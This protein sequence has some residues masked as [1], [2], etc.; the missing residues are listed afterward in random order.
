MTEDDGHAVAT[1]EEFLVVILDGVGV[2]DGSAVVRAYYS[3]WTT[4]VTILRTGSSLAQPNLIGVEVLPLIL[5]LGL[6]GP[7]LERLPV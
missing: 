1:S 4:G 5:Q 2:A 7:A 6:D 3:L